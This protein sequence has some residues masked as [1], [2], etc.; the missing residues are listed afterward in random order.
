[1]NGEP[2]SSVEQLRTL[3]DRYAGK[4][5]LLVMRGGRTMF[6]PIAIK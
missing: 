3:V 6:V 5:A 2:V 1:V 4:L